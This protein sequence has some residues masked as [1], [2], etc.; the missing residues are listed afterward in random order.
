MVTKSAAFPQIVVALTVAVLD[1]IDRGFER[2][3]FGQ[4]SNRSGFGASSD[5]TGFGQD[6]GF[7]NPGENTGLSDTPKDDFNDSDNQ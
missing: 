7:E 2:G 3:G 4:D 5:R 1:K 6:R